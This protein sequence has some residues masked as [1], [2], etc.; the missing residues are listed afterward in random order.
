MITAFDCE[1]GPLP[2]EQ[3]KALE[4]T[5][6]PP[7]NLKDP[8]KIAAAI[9]EKRAAWYER[10]ALSPL[11]GRILAI[12]YSD[13]IVH[14]AE[15]SADEGAMIGGFFAR[16]GPLA[17]K[18]EQLVG[19]NIHDFDLPFICRRALVHGLSIPPA[20]LP[21]GHSRFFWPSWLIDLRAIWGFGEHQPAGSLEVVCRTLGLG[22]K[23]GDGA[24]F[25]RLYFGTP[26][27]RAQALSYLA[28]D[29][30]LTAKLAARLG[31]R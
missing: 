7:G 2:D 23:N 21:T 17:P 28:N 5:F 8:T 6:E 9:E 18:R 30:A 22:Q 24:D 29:L 12:G 11:T 20:L 27:E 10:A 1:T 16:V 3:L 13:G 25:A 15:H 4:P 31:V 19:W 14:G 26:E